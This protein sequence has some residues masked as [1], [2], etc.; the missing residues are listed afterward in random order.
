MVKPLLSYGARVYA[1]SI[2]IFLNY[3]LGMG[4]LRY[5]LDY[6]EVGY[7]VTAITLAE[8]LWGVPNAFA[9]VLFPRI[10][11]ADKETQD[12]LTTTVCR[13][14][15]VVVLLFCMLA[16]ALGTRPISAI[17]FAQAANGFLLPIVAVYLLYVMNNR[18]LLGEFGN[19]WA[20]NV[21]GGLVVAVVSG[22]GVFKLLQVLGVV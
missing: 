15:A 19:G 7:Y 1:F 11:G 2:L 10:A 13:I 3:R 22:L 18:N 5:F 9:F 17:L 6:Q 8:L 20:S 12:R 14:T 21:V 4:M 16:A